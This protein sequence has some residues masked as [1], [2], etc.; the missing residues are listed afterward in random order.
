MTAIRNFGTYELMM[1]QM[2][3]AH[4]E[5]YRHCRIGK[6]KRKFPKGPSARKELLDLLWLPDPN[7]PRTIRRL[8]E[9]T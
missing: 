4:N 9:R 8:T 1:Q 2:T 5:K 7:D 6:V 3:E